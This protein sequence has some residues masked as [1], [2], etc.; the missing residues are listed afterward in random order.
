LDSNQDSS[1]GSF[2]Q[3][4]RNIEE[5]AAILCCIELQLYQTIRP[6]EFL[7]KLIWKGGMEELNEKTKYLF[8]L[9]DWANQ[10]FL[11]FFFSFFLFF[12]FFK[13]FI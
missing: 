13:K 9:I 5:L 6:E 11:F 8:S 2:L 1:L 4:S 7:E 10:V 3:V 12:L